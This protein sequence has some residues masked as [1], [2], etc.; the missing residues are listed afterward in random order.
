M[1]IMLSGRSGRSAR[2]AIALAC[3]A[4]TAACGGGSSGRRRRSRPAQP[5]ECAG[6][7]GQP[8]ARTLSIESGGTTREFRLFVPES[9]DPT[10]GV[11]LVL[12]FHGLASN[13]AAQGRLRAGAPARPVPI[14]MF[15]GTED[16][17]V[18]YAS[19]RNGF[20]RWQGFNGCTGEAAVS[21]ENGDTR[22][23]TVADCAGAATTTL[24]TVTGGGHTWPGAIERPNLGFTTMDIDATDAMWEFFAAHPQP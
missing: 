24:C 3:L 9:N 12:N 5:A 15:N 16:P 22:C 18:P 7:A 13:A 4:L 6:N 19:A 23:E 11:P 17:L 8:G 21:F 1:T 10:S 14:M 2:R 20:V